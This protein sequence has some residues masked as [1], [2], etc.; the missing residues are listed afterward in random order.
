[1]LKEQKELEKKHNLLLYNLDISKINYNKEL[2]E[3]SKLIDSL[4]KQTYSEFETIIID[5][6]STD[7]SCK[8]IEFC[9][10]DGNFEIS[11]SF[12]IVFFEISKRI[13][14]LY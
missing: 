10:S 5:D 14:S 7:N 3:K 2:S 1:M 4:K 6:C 13:A 8:I 12:R 9:I 11:F